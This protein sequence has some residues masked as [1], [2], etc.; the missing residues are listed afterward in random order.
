MGLKTVVLEILNPVTD[1]I[2]SF[3]KTGNQLRE[4]T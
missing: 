2:F 3:L 1:Q 4:E